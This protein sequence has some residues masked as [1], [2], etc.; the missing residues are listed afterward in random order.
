M[1]EV[2]DPLISPVSTATCPRAGMNCRTNQTASRINAGIST[3]VTKKMMKIR[4]RIRAA[5]GAAHRRPAPPRPRRSPRSWARSI[6]IDQRL[7]VHGDQAGEQVESANF[8]PSIESSMLFPNTQRNSMF[9]RCAD[10]R[11]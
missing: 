11:A 2:R 9:R 10:P 3:S 7:R 1:G 4:V 6:R 5:G 8:T